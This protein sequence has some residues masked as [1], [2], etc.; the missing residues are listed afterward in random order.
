VPFKVF[1]SYSHRD[2]ALRDR[3][4]K[5]LA[6][7][8][9]AGDIEDWHD[10]RIEA[11]T[12]WDRQIDENLKAADIILLLVSADFLASRYCTDI[13][14]KQAMRQHEA[15]TARV[16]PVILHPCYW[17]NAPFGKLQ[18]LPKDADPI[19]VSPN[20]DA[21][22]LNVVQG[23][24]NAIETLRAAAGATTKT[25][26]TTPPLVTTAQ[27][28]DFLIVEFVARRDDAGHDIIT[29]LR[30]ELAPG[31]QR[32]VVLWGAGGV[33]KTTLAAEA[34]R[35]LAAEYAGRVVWSSALG[36]EDYALATLLDETAAQLKEPGVR[37]LPPAPK[38]EAVADLLAAAP[39]LVVL[40][41][42]E[43]VA[44]DEQER[45]AAF[46]H[47]ASAAALVTTRQK[48]E[49]RRNVKVDAMAADE[50]R[51]YLQ[52]LIAQTND[53]DTFAQLDP[54]RII[55]AAARNPLLL[56]WVVAQID[57]AQEPDAVLA[58]LA[59]GAGDAAE[60]VFDHSFNLPQVTDDGRAAL[61]ALSLFT[62]DASR[63]ALAEVAGFA[64][65]TARL[66]A[67]L[68]PLAALWL[69]KTTAAGRRLALEALTRQLA[70]ARLQKDPRADEF[71]Q[72]YVACFLRYAEA[73]KQPTP[74][75]YD[76]LIAE[77]DNLLSATDAA[78]AS[79]DWQSVMSIRYVLAGMPN[80]VLTV[81]GYWGEA[82]RTCGLALAAART[83]QADGQVALWAHAAAVMHQNRGEH[84]EA[85]RL[86][87]ESLAIKK[88]LG[89][90][91]GIASTLHNLAAIAQAQ[92]ELAE[93]RR[94]YD[95]SLEIEKKLGNQSGI[96]ITLH[97]L[98]M[99][100]ED[101]GELAEARRLYDESLAINKKLGNQSGIASTLHEL[102]RLAQ[103]QGELDEA[104][105][106]YGES[107]AIKKKLGDQ[108]GIAITLAQMG[109]LAEE[110]GDKAEAARLLREALSIFERLKHPYAERARRELARVEG[111]GG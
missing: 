26:T 105:R 36:R 40:D 10:R 98:A 61:L 97:Q 92:G 50:A 91:R 3:L 74:E 15:G 42:F 25:T 63:E 78:A 79:A 29:R 82:L 30:A 37:Y 21:A 41:N 56:Q 58:D 87:D 104:R 110:E 16:I 96:A 94:L 1:Y 86:Y 93:A 48:L 72:R 81:R 62:P 77:L 49:G 55:A 99:L 7:L 65:D 71:R 39:V 8:K 44:A 6:T 80:A 95:E 89:D 70:E 18:A 34:A 28:P 88:K 24:L 75:N 38:A 84:A 45:V 51:A 73:H 20:Q 59:H 64:T 9:Q 47:A 85:R 107:L 76:A 46:L 32:L 100:A 108:R 66:N 57:G 83:A 19:S 33:G 54:D 13:E 14:V 68:K 12:E 22:F 35:T 103:A 67:A 43:T 101:Q 17:Q 60:R 106:L 31:Q 109:L 11:G 69:V 27:I 102:G 4:E 52:L 5:H 53:A 23:I 111:Q 90:Q 2:E